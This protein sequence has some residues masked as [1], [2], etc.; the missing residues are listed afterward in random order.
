M[1]EPKSW[2]DVFEKEDINFFEMT[3]RS[4]RE[5]FIRGKVSGWRECAETLEEYA[6]KMDKAD[7]GLSGNS[8]KADAA[9][10][11]AAAIRAQIQERDDE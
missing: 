2:S 9:R 3:T 10:E 11:I 6:D 1:G 7:D 5:A 4:E 8:F